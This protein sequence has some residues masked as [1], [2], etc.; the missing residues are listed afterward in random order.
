M[1]MPKRN[2]RE[3]SRSLTGFD[4]LAIMKAFR[5]PWTELEGMFAGRALLF[6]QLRR[7]GAKDADAYRVSMEITAGDIEDLFSIPDAEGNEDPT[8]G[9]MP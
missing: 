7:D 2:A 6:V 4:E 5:K 9:V 1:G 8:G 3:F